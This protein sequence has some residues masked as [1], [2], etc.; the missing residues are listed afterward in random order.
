MEQIEVYGLDEV[1]RAAAAVRRTYMGNATTLSEDA[2]LGRARDEHRD[3]ERRWGHGDQ[4]HGKAL[5][6]M[7]FVVP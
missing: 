5:V 3:A 4:L 1:R 2:Q 7:S 6:S